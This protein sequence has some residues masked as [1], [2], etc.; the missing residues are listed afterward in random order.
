V[1]V[2]DTHALVWWVS[3][4]GELSKPAARAIRKAAALNEVRV[5]SISVFEIATAVRRGRLD[6]GM[7]LRQWFTDLGSLPELSLQPVTDDI[8]LAAAGFDRGVPGDPAD[9]IIAA[10]AL[11]LAA[12]LVTKDDRLRRIPQLNTLW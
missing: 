5:S 10:T 7:P 11:S 3:G 8:A 1:I 9:R 2:L 4:A 6:L 12:V